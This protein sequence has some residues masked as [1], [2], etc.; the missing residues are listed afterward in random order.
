MSGNI[1]RALSRWGGARSAG[2]GGEEEEKEVSVTEQRC[3]SHS[4][5][6]STSAAASRSTSAAAS[7]STSAAAMALHLFLIVSVRERERFGD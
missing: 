7:R 3:V 1:K 2:R 5:S 4:S 6:R